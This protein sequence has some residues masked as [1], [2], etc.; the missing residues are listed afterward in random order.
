VSHHESPPLPTELGYEPGSA[1]AELAQALVGASGGT[2]EAILLYGS[3]LHG[4]NPDRHSA[5]DFVVIVSEYPAFYAALHGAGEIHRPHA[6]MSA[7]ARVLAPNVIAFTPEE[8]R[9]GIA[10]CLIVSGRDFETALGE[11]PPDHFILAR[12]VQEVGL[13]WV[14]DRAT[15]KWIQGCIDG[16]RARVLSWVGPFLEEPFDAEALGHRMLEVC[17]RGEFR[18]EARDR[19]AVVFDGQREHLRAV[20]SPGLEA[21]LAAGT[22][23]RGPDGLRFVTPP[24]GSERRRWR[25][26]FVRSKARTTTRWLKHVVTFDNWLP[27]VVRKVERRTGSKIELTRMERRWPL[28]FLWPRVVRVLRVRPEREDAP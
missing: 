26:Y 25:W 18:P 9:A 24:S 4:A 1:S 2:V 12:M 16:A 3:H 21:A 6:L 28:I 20:L 5:H 8:G 13:V 27:Y 14:Q 11:R 22:L 17:Y 10:K 7:V 23:T 19:A 15:R